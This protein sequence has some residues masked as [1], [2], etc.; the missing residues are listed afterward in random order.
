MKHSKKQI[1]TITI[2]E[3]ENFEIIFYKMI[4][5]FEFTYLPSSCLNVVSLSS[6]S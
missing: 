3:A 5:N 2:I 1:K 4:N 6:S